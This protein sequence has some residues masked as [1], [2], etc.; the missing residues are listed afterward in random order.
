MTSGQTSE[1]LNGQLP[2]FHFKPG[3]LLRAVVAISAQLSA[4]LYFTQIR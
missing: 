1:K 2:G 4:Y 3:I